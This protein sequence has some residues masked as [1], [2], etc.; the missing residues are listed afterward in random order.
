M[1][2]NNPND[3]GSNNQPNQRRIRTTVDLDT[4]L[5]QTPELSDQW[6]DPTIE[7]VPLASNTSPRPGRMIANHQA[8]AATIPANT[9][10]ANAANTENAFRQIASGPS[11]TLPNP[12]NR[13]NASPT[14][15]ANSSVRRAS[16][17]IPSA[18]A[19]P[20][21][22]HR[23]QSSTA[24]PVNPDTRQHPNAASFRFPKI[25]CRN[26]AAFGFTDCDI[27]GTDP[28]PCTNCQVREVGRSC[29][30]PGEEPAGD[31]SGYNGPGEGGAGGY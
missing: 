14:P 10:T 7:S 24:T 26:C 31:G 17:R 2:D 13:T 5:M 4:Y 18:S 9:T 27:A 1:T 16:A 30:F 12:S 23:S 15:T 19:S 3:G 25:E 6:D 29:Y 20:S 11:T 22:S 8:N 28:R 21:P